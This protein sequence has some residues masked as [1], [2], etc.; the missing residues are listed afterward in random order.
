[1]PKNLSNSKERSGFISFVV[2][3]KVDRAKLSSAH[4]G[5]FLRSYR[6]CHIGIVI[7]TTV[8]AAAP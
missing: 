3:N 8:I 6:H 1:M 5:I 2:N 4:L 7:E